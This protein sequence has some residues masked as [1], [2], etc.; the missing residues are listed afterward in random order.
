MMNRQTLKIYVDFCFRISLV[1][2]CVLHIFYSFKIGLIFDLIVLVLNT[3]T[4]HNM[5]GTHSAQFTTHFLGKCLWVLI[6]VVREEWDEFRTSEKSKFNAHKG[7][8]T[9]DSPDPL[10]SN[11]FCDSI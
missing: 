6:T 5:A 7:L 9:L 11:M 4:L 1:Q 2:D 8:L 3:Y 10:Q